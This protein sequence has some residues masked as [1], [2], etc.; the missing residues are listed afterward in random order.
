[1][2]LDATWMLGRFCAWAWIGAVDITTPPMSAAHN[3]IRMLLAN[4]RPVFIVNP[5]FV[6]VINGLAGIECF[7]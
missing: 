3:I 7:S 1:M 5:P 6:S 4:R 2:G